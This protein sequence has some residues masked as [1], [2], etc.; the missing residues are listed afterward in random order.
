LNWRSKKLITL[1]IIVLVLPFVTFISLQMK[2]AAAEEPPAV[3]II[4]V[5][6]NPDYSLEV[7]VEITLPGFNYD[8]YTET[9]Q[10]YLNQSIAT[11]LANDY[12]TANASKTLTRQ[13]DE[14]FA[15][16]ILSPILTQGSHDDSAY[17]NLTV[18]AIT[19]TDIKSTPTEWGKYV[20]I[21]TELPVMS[22]LKPNSPLEKVWGIYPVTVEVFDDSNLSLIEFYIDS[23]LR[24]SITAPTPGQTHFKWNWI[25]SA[26]SR[27]Q[28]TIKVKAVDDTPAKN[29]EEIAFTVEVVGPEFAYRESVPPTIDFND[30]LT[31]NA[32]MLVSNATLS[33]DTVI[34]H[35]AIDS[36]W[37]NYTIADINLD[38]YL[39]NFSFPTYPIGTNITWEFIVNN[40]EGQYHVFRDKNLKYWSVFSVH[41]DHWKPTVKVFYDKQLTVGEIVGV[42]V[43][44]T[45]QSDVDKCLIYYRISDG[46]W[47]SDNMTLT[48]VAPPQPKNETWLYFGYNFTET[49]EVF[50]QLQFYVWV[51]DSGG[52]VRQLDNNNDYYTITIIPD[53]LLAPN[54]TILSIPETLKAYQ[55]VTVTVQIEDA[56]NLTSVKLYYT[57]NGEQFSVAMQKTDVN[58]WSASFI[59]RASTGDKVKI[60][61]EATDEYYNTGITTVHQFD[62]VSNKEGIK[63]NNFLI[64]LML[65]VLLI[66][67]IVVSLLIIRP[68]K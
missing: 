36:V 8:Y 46:S 33:I 23:D 65:L 22:F 50:S 11:I 3:T 24:Y 59:L 16:N 30:T 60:W 62:V 67:P 38:N 31:L 40:T 64:L 66:A 49:L 32:T 4:D 12:S 19:N 13:D 63:H 28:H 34:L 42:N 35:Y 61:V 7:N 1:A 48:Q 17:Y 47:K 44:V 37:T 21:D 54:I 58:T 26:D 41:W 55:N 45:E 56:S 6:I 20:F 68:Q 25:C 52:N 57:I 51:N 39:F 10:L 2:N 18:V 14:T 5:V 53:D 9:L 29:T 43:N 15:T 27:G